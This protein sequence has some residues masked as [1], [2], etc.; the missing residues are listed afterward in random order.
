MIAIA[1]FLFS[2]WSW[3]Q[4]LFS[5]TSGE[6][7]FT[8]DSHR[9]LVVKTLHIIAVWKHFF[10]CW[11]N[12]VLIFF[13][14]SRYMVLRIW[15]RRELNTQPWWY[16]FN[17]S[18]ILLKKKEIELWYARVK[19]LLRVPE[20]SFLLFCS[21]SVIL[22]GNFKT[23]I[24]NVCKGFSLY[25]KRFWLCWSFLVVQAWDCRIIWFCLT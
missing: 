1:I 18:D 10:K 8:D 23:L 22:C 19:V 7:F 5:S 9:E 4:L 13:F 2:Q 11:I 14:L 24:K 20:R 12:L 17:Y 6:A 3:L 15:L 16:L 21:I 25:W